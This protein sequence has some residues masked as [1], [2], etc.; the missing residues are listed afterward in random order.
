MWVRVRWA[1]R[2]VCPQ[3]GLYT[4]ERG[5][6]AGAGLGTCSVRPDAMYSRHSLSASISDT[7]ATTLSG[8]CRAAGHEG[9]TEGDMYEMRCMR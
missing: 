4:R 5:G 8:S 9:R 1:E 2:G 3:A 7:S 6:G